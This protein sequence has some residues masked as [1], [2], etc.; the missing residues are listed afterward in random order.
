MAKLLTISAVSFRSGVN[1]LGDIVGVFADEHVFSPAEISGFKII[2]VDGKP[3]EVMV[4][5][6]KMKPDLSAFIVAD[7]ECPSKTRLNVNL[8]KYDYNVKDETKT[9]V[10]DACKTNIKAE[11]ANVEP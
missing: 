3:N 11:A 6:E 9:A 7:D 2:S 5:L 8:P 1:N 10:A 4:E